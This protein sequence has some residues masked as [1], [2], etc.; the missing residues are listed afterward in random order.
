M[1]FPAEISPQKNFYEQGQAQF[2]IKINHFQSKLVLAATKSNDDH[3]NLLDNV[4]IIL[5]S[6]KD[7]PGQAN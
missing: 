2:I 4:D 3:I 1:I 7:K 5:I 6:I